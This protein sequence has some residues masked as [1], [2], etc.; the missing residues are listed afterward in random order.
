MEIFTTIVQLILS[1]SILV[2]LHELGHFIP[3]KLFKTRVEKFYLFF[4]PWFS[5][6]KFKKGETEYGIGWLPLGGFVKISGMIDES[7]DT[8]QMKQEPKPWEFRSKPVWQRLIIMIGGVVVNFVLAI[9]IYSLISFT[10]GKN[11]V[12]NEDL[13]YGLQIL[14]EN[15][16]GNKYFQHGDKLL[17]IEGEE[18]DDFDEVNLKV[19]ID[20]AKNYTIDR[21]GETLEITIEEQAIDYILKEEKP[22][23]IPR[24]LTKIGSIADN[25]IAKINGLQI[26][27]EIIELNGRNTVY[28]N[29]FLEVVKDL[30]QKK[31]DSI[32]FKVKRKNEI[33]KI[34][35]VFD[36]TYTIGFNNKHKNIFKKTHIDFS[37]SQ[38]IPEGFKLMKNTLSGYVK[39]FNLVF[40]KKEALKKVGGF[41]AFGK[42]FSGGWNWKRFWKNTAFLSV[43]LAFMN[44]LPIPA[45]DGGHVLFLLYEM[46]SGRPPSDKFLE[47]AQIIGF[48]I[49]V[50]LMLLANG[51]DAFKAIFG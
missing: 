4:N 42:M 33:L 51:N 26:E 9:V 36:S 21:N 27:D 25:S 18:I 49:L 32:Q 37:F 20:Q 41:G 11:Y 15:L 12:K 46:I 45:L 2:V 34:S 43:I 50:S 14:D 10:W 48:L 3:A 22:L 35:A 44:I 7:M 23:F 40:T 30:K 24:F 16:I 38:S 13:T 17:A 19:L 6:F 47:K 8:E 31:Q 1:L 28:F 29:D 39:Q 5:L